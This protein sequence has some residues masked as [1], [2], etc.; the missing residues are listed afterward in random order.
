[1]TPK[2]ADGKVNS[3]NLDQATPQSDLGLQHVCLKTKENS[4]VLSREMGLLINAGISSGDDED[5]QAVSVKTKS[6]AKQSTRTTSSK[7]LPVANTKTVP[8]RPGRNQ[9][10][11]SQSR[12]PQPSQKF[13]TPDRPE[14]APQKSKPAAKSDSTVQGL[15][16]PEK[17]KHL[18]LGEGQ[19]K[20]KLMSPK[21]V[22]SDRGIPSSWSI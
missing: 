1:M 14:T 16:P 9:S 22:K 10:S 2:D 5:K 20:K 8:A 19:K 6:K 21:A 17:P 18:P 4:A 7:I 13:K 3:A 11:G 12:Q 15:K